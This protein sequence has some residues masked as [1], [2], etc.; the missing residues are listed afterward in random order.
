MVFK[1]FTFQIGFRL[2]ILLVFMMLFCYVL[3][4]KSWIISSLIILGIILL[5]VRNLFLKVTST[6]KGL[7]LFISQAQSND[8]G[9]RINQN[10]KGNGFTELNNALDQLLD[11]LRESRINKEAQYVLFNNMV[12]NLETGILVVSTN[13]EVLLSNPSFHELL[14]T[15]EEKNW[16][17][18]QKRIPGI[19]DILASLKNNERKI[20]WL[21][22]ENKKQQILVTRRKF[23]ISEMDYMFFSFQNI[24]HE[25]EKK[26][27]QSW[28][29]LIR[30]LTHEIMNSVSPIVSLG[31]TLQLL[32]KNAKSIDGNQVIETK[33]FEDINLAS[34]TLQNRSKGLMDFIQEY[35]RISKIPLPKVERT[36]LSRIFAEIKMLFTERLESDKIKLQIY[37]FKKEHY[38]KADPNLLSQVLMNLFYNALDALSGI[39]SPEINL[40]SSEN[41]NIT[42]IEMR[43]NGTG[44]D[45]IIGGDIFLPFFTTKENGSGIGLS[46]S[47]NIIVAHGGELRFVSRDVGT[48]IVIE[49]PNS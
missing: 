38:I 42:I 27:I 39:L 14:Q 30:I 16:L 31:E 7:A 24:H 17:R 22:G 46:L 34:S 40:I 45:P 11:K 20:I 25:L 1:K 9:T 26:E 43:D 28:H 33:I 3:L 18:L 15:P 36:N 23:R 49:L 19:S 41:N 29:K 21:N 13:N 12:R 4:I 5:L 37:T 8:F 44:I 32:L 35:S 47:K 6:N 48:S 2:G 10:P